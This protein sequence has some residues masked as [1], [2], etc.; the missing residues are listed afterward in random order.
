MWD[1]QLCENFFFFNDTATT[2]IYTLSLHDALPIWIF[3]QLPLPHSILTPVL[4][5][6]YNL[7][8]VI[9]IEQLSFYIICTQSATVTLNNRLTNPPSLASLLSFKHDCMISQWDYLIAKANYHMRVLL[10]FDYKHPTLPMA[11]SPVLTITPA[12]WP[13]EDLP[14]IQT[15][16]KMIY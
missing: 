5:A 6:L 15:Y 2:E 9:C 4:C 8:N 14:I 12:C 3:L 1:I 7:V 11:R 16:G 13:T 10:S